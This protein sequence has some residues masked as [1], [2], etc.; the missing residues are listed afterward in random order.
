MVYTF[1]NFKYFKIIQIFFFYLVP[2]NE[3][4]ENLELEQNSIKQ[5]L[6]YAFES[7][8]SHQ[9]HS[10]IP[11]SSNLTDLLTTS[12][13]THEQTELFQKDCFIEKLIPNTSKIPTKYNLRDRNDLYKNKDTMIQVLHQ[14]KSG[15]RKI[16]KFAKTTSSAGEFFETE[17]KPISKVLTGQLVYN[18]R[19]GKGRRIAW[20]TFTRILWTLYCNSKCGTRMLF[21]EWEK[22]KT[23]AV[24]IF[25]EENMDKFLSKEYTVA[26]VYRHEESKC[27]NYYYN[28]IPKDTLIA[29]QDERNDGNYQFTGF[30]FSRT[31]Y[32]YEQECIKYGLKYCR[33]PGTFSEDSAN[34]PECSKKR[35]IRE[36]FLR[37][38]PKVAWKIKALK[39][40]IKIKLKEITIESFFLQLKFKTKKSAVML[41]INAV[42]TEKV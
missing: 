33:Y 13:L 10:S 32:D 37:K 31:R 27:V 26:I 36:K 29:D 22:T 14:S 34:I 12:T 3:I 38:N 11:S 35:A 18:S 40:K 5:N 6:N 30:D 2:S 9:D 4:L 1:F 15:S 19:D 25:L 28:M 17:K 39:K 7:E 16:Q 24:K 41:E 8:K 42:K 23:G 20:T 21:S